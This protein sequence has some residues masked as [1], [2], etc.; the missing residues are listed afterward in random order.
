MS[1]PNSDHPGGWGGL[2]GI[3]YRPGSAPLSL[4]QQQQQQQ[5]QG[6]GGGGGAVG[7]RAMAPHVRMRRAFDLGGCLGR[8]CVC[9][10]LCVCVCVCVRVCVRARVRVRVRVCV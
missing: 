9:V 2:G 3:P 6:G 5:Q 4:S 10:C 1:N 8:I 7:D